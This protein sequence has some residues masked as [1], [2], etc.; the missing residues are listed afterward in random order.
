MVCLIR[1]GRLYGLR[2]KPVFLPVYAPEYPSCFSSLGA[3]CG[4]YAIARSE[5]TRQSRKKSIDR[6]KKTGLLRSARNDDGAGKPRTVTPPS[7][8]FI[9]ACIPSWSY[10]PQN[11]QDAIIIIVLYKESE[12]GIGGREEEEEEEAGRHTERRTSETNTPDNNR[13][14]FENR[15]GK[16]DNAGHRDRVWYFIG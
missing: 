3:E 6:Q 12:T 9:P 15:P 16:S 13:I 4:A 8:A 5:A 11:L 7:F 14:V 1:S 2:V 10:L